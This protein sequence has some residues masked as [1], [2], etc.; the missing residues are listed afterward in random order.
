MATYYSVLPVGVTSRIPA[1]SPDI[2]ETERGTA[3][4]KRVVVYSQ[5]G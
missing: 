1:G 3:M 5:P 2:Q 4:A